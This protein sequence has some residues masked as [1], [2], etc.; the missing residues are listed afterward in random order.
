MVLKSWRESLSTLQRHTKHE[1]QVLRRDR[2]NGLWRNHCDDVAKWRDEECTSSA[3]RADQ[4]NRRPKRVRLCVFKRNLEPARLAL[5]CTSAGLC[6]GVAPV[7]RLAFD[8]CPSLCSRQNH[9]N[10]MQAMVYDAMMKLTCC[11]GSSDA[12]QCS[13]LPTVDFPKSWHTDTASTPKQDLPFEVVFLHDPTFDP[14]SHKLGLKALKGAQARD[15]PG[16]GSGCWGSQL[17]CRLDVCW[18]SFSGLLLNRT[19]SKG[20]SLIIPSAMHSGTD[21]R[22][23]QRKL[24]AGLS[25]NS[26]IG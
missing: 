12:E 6:A 26:R 13:E 23:C 19:A 8:R 18:G 16:P 9:E 7:L 11:D 10:C 15:R 25:V 21:A 14:T 20:A 3:K 4:T 1:E 2:E 5:S 22:D 17:Y 24:L